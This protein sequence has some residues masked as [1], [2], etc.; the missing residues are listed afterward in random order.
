[1]K[2]QFFMILFLFVGSVMYTPATAQSLSVEA[3]ENSVKKDGKYALLVT[4]ARHFQAAVMTG[5]E[6]KTAHPKL[7]FEIVLIGPGVKDLATDEDLKSFVETSEKLG[8]RIVV[9]EFAMKHFGI[10]KSQYHSSIKTTP[11]GFIYMFGLQEN[12]FKA[13]TL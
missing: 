6:L 4:N 10:S 13:I 7:Q 2:N 1:M 11:D 3:I 8:I 12:G 9:C 5:E